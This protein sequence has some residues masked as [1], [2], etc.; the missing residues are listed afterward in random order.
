VQYDPNR[1]AA[2]FIVKTNPHNECPLFRSW[3]EEL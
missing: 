1:K 2:S 3:M